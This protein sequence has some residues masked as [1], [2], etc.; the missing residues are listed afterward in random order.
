MRIVEAYKTPDKQETY[1]G[2]IRMTL[3]ARDL[4]MLTMLGMP[5]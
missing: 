3:I 2:L 5:L 4:P 1:G